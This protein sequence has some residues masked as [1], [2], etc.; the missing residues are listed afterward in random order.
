M[1]MN[2]T[3]TMT[4]SP[5]PWGCLDGLTHPWDRGVAANDS[6]DYDDYGDL[7]DIDGAQVGTVFDVEEFDYIW[8]R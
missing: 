1:N 4:P 2:Q 6:L 8:P 5:S 7:Q 3:T